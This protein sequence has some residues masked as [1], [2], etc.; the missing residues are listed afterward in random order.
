MDILSTR[1]LLSMKMENFLE[2][3]LITHNLFKTQ[4]FINLVDTCLSKYLV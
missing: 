1:S 4:N 2:L 3:H